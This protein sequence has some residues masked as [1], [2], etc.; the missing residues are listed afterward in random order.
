MRSEDSATRRGCNGD[1]TIDKLNKIAVVIATAAFI[2]SVAFSAQ[3]LITETPAAAKLE[4]VPERPTPEQLALLK[5]PEGRTAFVQ[6]YCSGCHDDIQAIG[7][8]VLDGLPT[9]DIHGNADIWENVIRRLTTG[10]MPPLSEEVRPSREEADAMA[11][12]LTADLDLAAEK[13]P[14]A[15]RT[16]IRRLN[17]TE[18][19]NAV[20]D[21]LN[22]D[23]P[24]EG[25]LPR[26]GGAAGFDNIADALSFSP[27][28]LEAYMKVARKVSDLALSEVEASVV[29]DRYAA[30]RTQ[31]IWQGP[32]MPFGTRGGVRVQKFFPRSGEYD[33]RA[34]LAPTDLTPLE[35]VRFFHTRMRVPAG[36]H[37]FIATFP[38]SSTLPEGPVPSIAG[39]GGTPVGGPLDP[40]G[41]AARPKIIFMLDGAVIKEFGVT[42][43][44][45]SEAA[46]GARHGPPVLARVEIT[47]P[48]DVG[49]PAET[50]SRQHI[51]Q[52][53]PAAT[54]QEAACAEQILTTILRRA[55]RRDVTV[56]DAKPY[57]ATFNRSRP[58][59]TFGASI[60][61]ALRDILVSPEFLFRI[62]RASAEASS[63]PARQI[64]DFA[65]ASKLSFFLWSSIPDDELLDIASKGRLQ[66]PAVLDAQVKRMMADGKSNALIDNFAMQWLGVKNGPHPLEGFTPVDP[67]YDLALGEAFHTELRLFLTAVMRE[68]RSV[69]D[70]INGNYSFVNER[71]ARNYGIPAVKGPGFRRI[72]WSEDSP[73]GGILGMGAILMP[74]SHTTSTSPVYRGEWVL[75]SLL[76]S[77]PAPPPNNVPPL[78]DK[79]VNGRPL[80]LR[81][82]TE[83]HRADPVC[84][85]CHVG[86]DPYGFALENFD[87]LGRWRDK[88]QAGKIDSFATLPNGVSF[89][90]PVGLRK[91]LTQHSAVFA[92]ATTARMMT[93]ALGR[94]LE[95]RDMATVRAIS[96]QAAPE[97]RFNDL[98]MGVVR[99][100]PFM[101]KTAEKNVDG[102]GS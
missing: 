76:N 85:S 92:Q 4:P 40:M 33:L 71:L 35:G 32:D 1:A 11:Q 9:D 17:R 6:K 10:E 60:A 68:N 62:E 80:S 3:T 69:M 5:T 81:E 90:G 16:V 73:R 23:F 26:D 51:L 91:T 99:S 52:C 56:E 95:G 53:R 74:N 24:Y 89:A 50:P 22:I 45:A 54:A 59:A 19:G 14:F 98:V 55:W 30:T 96:K 84:A 61:T 72:T 97:Y 42:G 77:P 101:K 34:F 31:A 70:L 15:G 25:E 8:L 7:G 43:P 37:T 38:Q 27:V 82:Q 2:P 79:P 39:E 102:E 36:E 63:E 87:V 20:R 49:P 86:M 94:Q 65:L 18:Y 44:S 21:L 93:Y 67:D 88:D 12:F 57:L 48:Y 66:D 64:D 28:L 29:T 47:G 83:R 100:T 13:S 46:L 41:S 75:T 58:D 78:D